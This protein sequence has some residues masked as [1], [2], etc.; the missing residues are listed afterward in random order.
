MRVASQSRRT[1]K[2]PL[3][4]LNDDHSDGVLA[5]S[6]FNSPPQASQSWPCH[7]KLVT[8][9]WHPQRVVA[10]LDLASETGRSKP[11][12]AF[13]SHGLEEVVDHLDL[14]QVLQ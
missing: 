13:L 11:K 3:L 12:M 2:I 9:R 6:D 10:T 14:L 1:R 8:E 7:Q 5:F 4:K